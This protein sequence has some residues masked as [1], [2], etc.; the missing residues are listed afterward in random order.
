MYI[1]I[2]VYI[3]S[4][5]VLQLNCDSAPYKKNRAIYITDCRKTNKL[6]YCNS[7]FHVFVSSGNNILFLILYKI[8]YW[9]IDN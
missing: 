1:Y 3:S 4:N 2:Y 9:N 8:I 7:E 6:I 5:N